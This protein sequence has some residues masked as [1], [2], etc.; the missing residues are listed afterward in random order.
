MEEN[1]PLVDVHPAGSTICQEI[2]VFI[3]P[4]TP[5]YMANSFYALVERY[6]HWYSVK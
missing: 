4:F 5:L 2:M 3:T 1:F 6:K